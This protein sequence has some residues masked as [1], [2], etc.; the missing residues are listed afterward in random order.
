MKILMQVRDSKDLILSFFPTF[1]AYSVI[2]KTFCLL[3]RYDCL[4]GRISKRVTDFKNAMD[5]DSLG[6]ISQ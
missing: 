6:E 5:K 4:A 3:N 1:Y 2:K